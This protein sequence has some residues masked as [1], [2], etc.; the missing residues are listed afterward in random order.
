MSPRIQ[1]NLRQ[2]R[3]NKAVKQGDVQFFRKTR[4]FEVLHLAQEFFRRSSRPCFE[5]GPGT[6]RFGHDQAARLDLIA[7]GQGILH[8]RPLRTRIRADGAARR[9]APP[10]LRTTP[11]RLADRAIP[12]GKAPGAHVSS[13][14]ACSGATAR[15][16]PGRARP[17]AVPDDGAAG[18]MRLDDSVEILTRKSAA[19]MRPEAQRVVHALFAKHG[20]A[21]PG[22]ANSMRS[23]G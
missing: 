5:K 10:L 9:M 16:R 4:E 3:K 15:S 12:L 17:R 13:I 19:L 8:A 2:R 11:R 6:S 14:I 20:S 23:R 7:I 22:T 18:E 21:C 1:V